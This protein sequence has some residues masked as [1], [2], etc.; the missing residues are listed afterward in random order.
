MRKPSLFLLLLLFAASATYAQQTEEDPDQLDPNETIKSKRGQIILPEAGEFAIGFD[1]VPFLEYFGNIFNGTANN[2]VG[3]DFPG[4]DQQVFGKY[5]LTDDMAVRGRLAVEQDRITNRNRVILDNQPIPDPDIEV[6]DEWI[7]NTTDVTLGGGLEI[8]R[9]L[10][11]VVGV[12]GGEVSVMYSRTKIDYDYGNP[13]SEG[14][15]SPTSTF[16]AVVNGR[17]ERVKEEVF[18]RGL[19]AG[20]TGFAGVEYFVAPKVSIGAEFTL[21]FEFMKMYRGQNTFEFW[22]SA[23]SSVQTR[24]SVAAGGNSITLETGNAGGSINLMFYF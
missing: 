15:Q 8:R 21:G 18:N 3:A 4:V 14:N 5:F 10:G 23:S 16:G 7:E 11:R 19:G 22:D 6:T 17:F 20:V 12:F 24:K 1:A 2:T 9:G 13:I